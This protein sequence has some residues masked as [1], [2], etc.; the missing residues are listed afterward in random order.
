MAGRLLPHYDQR[1]RIL[2]YQAPLALAV[3][4]ILWLSTFLLSFGLLLWPSIGNLATALRE[5][6][7][8][9]LT[10]GFAS[11]RAGGPTV[12]DFV[13]GGTGLIVVALQIAYLPT[14]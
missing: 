8:S 1:Y 7:S 2:A 4:L 11:T 6:G 14:L 5:S 13:A 12:I 9:L 3:V 10:L